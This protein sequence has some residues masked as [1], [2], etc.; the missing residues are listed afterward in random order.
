MYT[1]RLRNKNKKRSTRNNKQEIANTIME[2]VNLTP[3]AEN[4]FTP[5]QNR[6]RDVIHNSSLIENSSKTPRL[7]IVP[8]TASPLKFMQ[9]MDKRFDKLTEQLTEQLQAML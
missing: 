8:N 1:T 3:N 5:T 9:T 2:A 6:L 7:S 4:P